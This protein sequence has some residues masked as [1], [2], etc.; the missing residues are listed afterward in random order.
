MHKTHWCGDDTGRMSLALADQIAEF[1]QC[2]RGIAKDKECIRMFLYRQP[3]A[4]LRTGDVLI[5]H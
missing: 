2:R 4:S 5:D 1:H 3:D